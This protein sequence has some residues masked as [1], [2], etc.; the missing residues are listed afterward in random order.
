MFLG[1]CISAYNT[2]NGGSDITQQLFQNGPSNYDGSN[3]N[4]SMEFL[5]LDLSLNTPGSNGGSDAWTNYHGNSGQAGIGTFNRFAGANH[6]FESSE[7][8]L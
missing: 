3:P 2:N 8:N 6:L 5:N 7:S 1:D 4:P